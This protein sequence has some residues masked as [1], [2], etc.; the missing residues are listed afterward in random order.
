MTRQT[1]LLFILPFLFFYGCRNTTPASVWET[2]YPEIEK[3]I[4][5]PVFRQTEYNILDFKA[6]PNQDTVLNHKAINQAIERCHAEGGGRVI[7]PAGIW[8]TGPITLKSNV[9][10]H[11]DDQAI[12]LFTTDLSQ[13]P[14]ALTRWEG[15]DCYNYQP[16]IYA[17]GEKNIAITGHG[18]I[19]GGATVEDWWSMN[20]N[21][22][23]GWKEGFV[24][25]KIGR[26]VLFDWNERSVPIEERRL[27]DGYGMRT[28]LINFYDC[29]NILIENITLLRSPFWSLH[30]LLCRNITVRGVHFENEGPN[31]DGCDPESCR[32]M[33]IEGC[34]FDTGDDCIAIKSGRNNDGRRWNVPSENIIVRNCV[35]RDGHG[36]V[37][38]GS[39]ISGGCRNLFVENCEMD[40]PQ[41]ERVIRIK[42]SNCR[43]GVVENVYVRH[44]R[45]GQCVEAVLKINLVYEPNERCATKV[46]P[47]VRNVFLEDVSCE[48]SRYGVMITALEDAVNVSNIELKECHFNGVEQGYFLSGEAQ[49]IHFGN[50]FI[51]GEKIAEGQNPET[52]IL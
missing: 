24:S 2:V 22:R 9:E 33:L 18:I 1:A 38:I 29:E 50:V 44:V 28:T 27:G 52:G 42:T 21:P 37:V 6:V 13:Y 51:N 45:A 11:L 30:P 25:Q 12:L 41:L 23:F 48:Q 39:E 5:P 46:N 19:D 7:I 43:G 40:S 20:G 10:L 4:Q 17:R 14:L 34:Y 16:M 3:R 8:H 31:G 32:D 49:K 15:V 35:M 47:I 26:P 36:G